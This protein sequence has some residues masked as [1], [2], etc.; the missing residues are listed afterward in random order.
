MP[1]RVAATLSLSVSKL[2]IASNILSIQPPSHLS[3]REVKTLIRNKKKANFHCKTGGYNP[4]QDSPRQLPRH[5]QTII[6]HLKTGHCRLNSHLK[7]I[8]VK[9]SAQYPVER[10]TKH[11]NTTY[12]PAHS[13]SKQGNRY[14]PLAC[15]SKPSSGDLQRIV[16][17]IQEC[18][19]YWR[20][21]IVNV[22][23]A[24]KA[25]EEEKEESILSK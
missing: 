21:D 5:Q 18:G 12:S 23:I 15:P 2:T 7:R 13:T 8:G 24:S 4:N 10:R 6:F 20:E 19:T 3:Y 17:D 1:N 14:G 11:Q 9:T 25:E 16:P 22:I